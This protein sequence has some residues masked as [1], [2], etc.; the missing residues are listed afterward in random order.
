MLLVIDALDEMLDDGG[1][2]FPFL[3]TEGL[4]RGAYVVLTTRPDPRLSYLPQGPYAIEHTEYHLGPLSD[5]ELAE[6]F[7][8]RRVNVNPAEAE[9]IAAAALGH[10]LYA[11]AVADALL[12]NPAFDLRDLPKRAE[13]FFRR[14]VGGLQGVRSPVLDGVLGLICA[15]RKPLSIAELGQ[16]LAA[17]PRM[18]DEQGIRLIRPFLLA[19]EGGFIFYHHK[20]HEFISRELHFED[21]IQGFHQALARWLDSPRCHDSDYRFRHLAYH[22]ERRRQGGPECGR[23]LSVLGCEVP[24]LRLRSA[25]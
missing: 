13:D 12:A 11:Q 20:F 19:T 4:P 3:V 6:L 17:T 1:G 10:P 9:R 7:R 2:I 18:I 22:L 21:E 15:A 8:V 16:M 25:G 24:P 14:A 23:Q 5:E